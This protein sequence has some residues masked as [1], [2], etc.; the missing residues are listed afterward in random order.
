MISI[1]PITIVSLAKRFLFCIVITGKRHL[2]TFSQ[3][4]WLGGNKASFCSFLTR[5]AFAGDALV[6]CQS[7]AGQFEDQLIPKQGGN[8]A[9]YVFTWSAPPAMILKLSKRS[10]R[11]LLLQSVL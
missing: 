5:F 11:Q 7:K 9:M 1:F 2:Q 8:A 3:G 10:L 6:L 4:I